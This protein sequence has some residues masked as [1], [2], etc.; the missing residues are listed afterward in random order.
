MHL[1]ISFQAVDVLAVMTFVRFSTVAKNSSS[2]MR[3]SPF[4]S[5]STKNARLRSVPGALL[6]SGTPRETMSSPICTERVKVS[7][8]EARNERKWFIYF[9]AHLRR[10]TALGWGYVSSDWG[11]S[12]LL[13]A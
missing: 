5:K 6:S 4:T 1:M 11:L 10:Q 13:H 2:E 3:P 9:I 12:V 7:V 8:R